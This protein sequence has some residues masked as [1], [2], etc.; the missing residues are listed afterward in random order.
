MLVYRRYMKF[1]LLCLPAGIVLSSC[2]TEK[3]TIITRGYHNVTSHYNGFFNAREKIKDGANKLAQAHEDKYDRILSV[4]KYADAT[5]AKSVFPQ[6]DEA[7]KKLS[8]V[9]ERHTI[10]EKSGNEIP[11]AVKWIDDSWLLIGKA[12]FYKYETFQALETFQFVA[13]QYKK[14][15]IRY[16]AILWMIQTH[17][18]LGNQLDAENLIDFLKND[19]KFPGELEG[20]FFAVQADFYLQKKDYIKA[21]DCLTKAIVFAKKKSDRIRYTFIL[22]QVYQYE[23]DHRKSTFYYQQ[24]IKMNPPYEMAFNAKINMAR[25]FDVEGQD[26]RTIKEELDKMRRDEKNKEYLDQIYYALAGLA[27]REKNTEEAVKYLNLSIQSSITNTNQKALS[28]LELADIC[29]EQHRY[30]LAETYYDSAASL[31]TKDYPD[32]ETILERKSVLGSLV[33]NLNIIEAEDSLQK[34]AGMSP[35]ER[36]AAIDKAIKKALSEQE[37]KKREAEEKAKSTPPIQNNQPLNQFGGAWY[38]Y[39]PNT[40]SMG[41]TEFVKK[42]GNRPLEDNWR[43]SNKESVIAESMDES[44]SAAQEDTSLDA[45]KDKQK[46]LKN[47]PSSPAQV[48]LSNQKIIDAYYAIGGIYKEQLDDDRE[49]AKTIEEL[50]KRFPDNKYKLPCYYQLYRIYSGLGQTDK[51][52]H[53]K[54]ILLNNYPGSEYSLLIK[55]PG[56]FKDAQSNKEKA[57]S[58]YEETFNAF[59]DKQYEDV[60]R[61]KSAADSLYPGNELMPKFAYLRALSIGKTKDV[62]YFEAALND[63]TRDYPADPVRDQAKEILAFIAASGS[64]GKPDSASRNN[65]PFSLLPDTTHFY[66]VLITDEKTDLN[67]LKVKISDYNGKY[68]STADLLIENLTF[69]KNTQLISVKDFSNRQQAM[70]YFY[71]IRESNEVFGAFAPETLMQFTISAGNYA[72]LYRRKNSAEYLTFFQENYMK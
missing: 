60:I 6:M 57:R 55:N 29:F 69:D 59:R 34:I 3:N 33:R 28:S 62:K 70:D 9:I 53:Y 68:Y 17:A 35:K 72:K 5:K 67:K 54:N 71:G 43:R 63:V 4:F 61:R 7:I 39:N 50:L 49:A 27:R 16:Q 52:E 18:R 48:D 14:D 11:G 8:L 44:T 2:S 13:S 37:Q 10:K 46:Y 21:E 47:I 66:V 20:A 41:L 38:F 42:W 12:R 64:T 40:V 36:D 24:V 23:N 65:D 26:S 51:A 32:Y 19:K 22:A 15:P 56:A 30:K 45:L 31:L 58:F 1:L 25:S